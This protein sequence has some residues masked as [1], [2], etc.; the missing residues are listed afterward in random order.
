MRGTVPLPEKFFEFF[1]PPSRGGWK[2]RRPPSY[3]FLI[4]V[5][6]HPHGILTGLLPISSPQAPAKAATAKAKT[7]VQILNFDNATCG[8]AATARQKP[9]SSRRNR[10][11]AD[12]FKFWPEVSSGL[13]VSQGPILPDPGNSA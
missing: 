1:D 6:P 8:R 11:A 10:A 2:A 4:P 3:E 13:W 12:G 7:M 5:R 9:D